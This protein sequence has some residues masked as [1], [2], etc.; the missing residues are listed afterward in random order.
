[1]RTGT[2]KRDTIETKIE[3][4]LELDGSGV[5]NVHCG[6]GFMDHM[7]TL[8][9]F[10]SDMDLFVRCDGDTYVDG[11]HSVEDVGIALGRAISEALGDRAGIARYGSF[12]LPMDETLVLCAL[13]ISGRSY[14]NFDVAM[15]RATVGDFDTELVKE[16]FMAVSRSLGLTLHFKLMAGEN[17]HHIIEA[18]FKGF[19]RALKQAFTV[20]EKL[21]GR[22][23]SSKGTIL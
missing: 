9:A 18:C 7:L 21:K 22:M 11:H 15:P 1:M 10:H 2:I 6:V 8:M 14:L 23:P 19:G 12:L 4:K 5:V 20:D 3:L 13:D 17:T 16:F